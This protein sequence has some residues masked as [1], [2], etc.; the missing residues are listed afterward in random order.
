[1]FIDTKEEEDKRRNRLGFHVFLSRYIYD[2]CKLSVLQQKNGQHETFDQ[3][4]PSDDIYIDSTRLLIDEKVKHCYIM[5][6]A[7][8]EW[9]NMYNN[10]MKIQWQKSATNLNARKLPGK[11]VNILINIKNKKQKIK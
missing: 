11:F 8:N 5:K 1:M 10:N 6:L 9:K 4:F 3:F 7:C 2:F